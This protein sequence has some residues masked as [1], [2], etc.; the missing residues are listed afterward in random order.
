MLR[1]DERDESHSVA[2]VTDRAVN[3]LPLTHFSTM[4][5][6]SLS[7]CQIHTHTHTMESNLRETRGSGDESHSVLLSCTFE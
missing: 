2:K 1:T 3:T 6:L 5:P 7:L 4:E